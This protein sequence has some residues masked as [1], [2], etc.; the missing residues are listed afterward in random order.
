MSEKYINGRIVGGYSQHESHKP[1]LCTSAT[2]GPCYSLGR[3][4]DCCGVHDERDIVECSRCGRQW[5]ESCS[6]DEEFS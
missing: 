1:E 5:T 2:G 6:F 4:V 3:C